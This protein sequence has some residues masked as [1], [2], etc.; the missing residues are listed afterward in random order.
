MEGDA[1]AGLAAVAPPT[2]AVMA[3]VRLDGA[4][5]PA[6]NV[7]TTRLTAAFVGMNFVVRAGRHRMQR[8]VVGLTH[9]PSDGGEVVVAYDAPSGLHVAQSIAD[10]R[11]ALRNNTQRLAYDMELSVL[12]LRARQREHASSYAVARPDIPL[13][14]GLPRTAS[15]PLQQVRRLVTAAPR[16]QRLP[17]CQRFA[18]SFARSFAQHAHSMHERVGCC[19]E[20][21]MTGSGAMRLN[22]RG[23]STQPDAFAVRR[24]LGT[25]YEAAR[26]LFVRPF[27]VV[28]AQNRLQDRVARFIASL[29]NQRTAIE[30]SL[31]DTM[32]CAHTQAHAHMPLA[33]IECLHAA[34]A[35]AFASLTGVPANPRQE[36]AR[37]RR[38]DWLSSRAGQLWVGTDAAAHAEY[39]AAA[40]TQVE[41]QRRNVRARA[42]APGGRARNA[43]AMFA[44]SRHA[45]EGAAYVDVGD[46]GDSKPRGAWSGNPATPAS[47][48]AARCMCTYCG[49]LLYPNEAEP[50]PTIGPFATVWCGGTLCCCKGAVV[51]EPVERAPAMEAL[52]ASH[53]RVLAAHARQLNNAMA[54]ASH[55]AER[56]LPLPGTSSW[57][58]SVSIDGRLHHQISTLLP[59]SGHTP[60][61]AQLYVHDPAVPHDVCALRIAGQKFKVGA[62]EL[63]RIREVLAALHDILMQCN[64]YVQDVVTAGEIFLQ[65]GDNTPT[66]TFAIGN[67]VFEHCMF[68]RVCAFDTAFDACVRACVRARVCVCI[69]CPHLHIC[70]T[71]TSHGT[72]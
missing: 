50:A 32:L 8:R 71:L 36:H 52:W 68:D 40:H 30:F 23:W 65:L 9:T 1:H 21:R 60:R 47:A 72:P 16:S 31:H 51:L 59:S 62:S 24:A 58:P 28:R 41:R 14:D 66:V 15:T 26:L 11:A 53:G 12:R 27:W 6:L 10:V 38:R 17:A 43:D 20:F 48:C 61:Y 22:R 45:F 49:A 39:A 55:Y 4:V 56:T 37:L 5:L 44:L 54:L 70:G 42:D 34:R 57:R 35:P 2:F 19:C 25:R 3:D 63:A 67:F 7:D 33:S 69:L 18:R 46:L 64:D 29:N 13:L